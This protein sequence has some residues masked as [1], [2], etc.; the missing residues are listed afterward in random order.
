MTCLF[1]AYIASVI[2]TAKIWYEVGKLVEREKEK[3]RKE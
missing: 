1:I 2:F 3:R